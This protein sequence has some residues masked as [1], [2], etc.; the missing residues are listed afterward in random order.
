MNYRI[1]LRL[2]AGVL[3]LLLIVLCT[4]CTPGQ[5]TP[6]AGTTDPTDTTAAPELKP[7]FDYLTEDLTPYV[8]LG[9]YKGLTVVRTS[10]ELTDAEFEEHVQALREYYATPVEIT[11]RPAAQGDT[12]NFDFEGYIDGEKFE[13]GTATGASI[14]LNGNGGYID[15]F[16]EAI[17]GKMPGESF[18]INTTFPADYHSADLQGKAA[19][20]KCTLNYIE[21]NETVLPELNDQFAQSISEFATLDELLADYRVQL[22]TSKAQQVKNQLYVDAW[23]QVVEGAT[24]HQYP[25]EQVEFIYQ[26]NVVYYTSIAS[27]YYGLEY[28]AYLAQNNKTDAGVYEEARNYVKE[29]MIFYA[30]LKAENIT[31]SDEEYTEKLDYYADLLGMTVENMQ[32]QYTEDQIRDGMLW[33]MVQEAVLGWANIVDPA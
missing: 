16:V 26:Q 29:D 23:S 33:D 20:F 4:A 7:P 31:L 27:L 9:N 12:C 13:G 14:T 19:V 5:T 6:S 3:A 24:I 17:V 10:A 2:H 18:D 25:T 21:G 28:E 8:T 15:G 32:L 22:E 1:S 11:D 30:I